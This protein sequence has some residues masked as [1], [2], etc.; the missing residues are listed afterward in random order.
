MNAALTK[1]TALNYARTRLE[2]IF[3]R[4]NLVICW[5]PIT[6][7]AMVELVWFDLLLLEIIQSIQCSLDIDECSKTTLTKATAL[8]YV[9]K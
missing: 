3:A 1:A 7:H 9:H 4:V 6:N 5:E 2:V 8:N